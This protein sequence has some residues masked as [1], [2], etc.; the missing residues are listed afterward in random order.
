MP[1]LTTV[2]LLLLLGLTPACGEAL[3][4]PRLRPA[5]TPDD[6]PALLGGGPARSPRLAS[7]QIDARLDDARHVIEARQ[8]LTWTNGGSSPVSSMPLHLYL[9][10]FANDSTLLMT[11]LRGQM[12]R[13]EASAGGWGWIDVTSISE[14]LAGG[15]GPGPELRG[16]ARFA[17]DDHTVLELPLPRVV[18]P[19]ER[20]ELAMTFTAQLPEVFARTGHRGAFTMVGQWFPKPGVRVG[21]PGQETWS[22]L[23]FHGNA[24]FFADFGVYDVRLTVPQTHVIAATGVLTEST[25]HADGT[26]TLRYLAEDVHDFAWMADP[27]ME[28]ISALAQVGEHTVQV[29]VV[30]RPA[31]RE[32]ARRHLAAGVGAIEQFSARFGAYPWS[33]M[34]IVD[35]PLDAVDGAGGMEYPTL[36]TTA[37]DTALARPGM[38][39]PEF[40]TI[41]EIGHNWF[42]G[43]LASDEARE[44]WLDEGVNEWAD[45]VVMA[46]LYGEPTSALD[47]HGW[48]AESFR[49]RRALADD[50]ASLPAPIASAAAAF[51]DQD[52][53]ASA[54]Y[55]APMAALRT[56][57]L[58]V[59]RDVFAAR[60]KRY[61]QAWAFRHPTGEDLIAALATD[62]GPVDVRAVLTPALH[63]IGAVQL[64]IRAADCAPLHPPRGRFVDE[65]TGASR[66]VIAADAPATGAWRCQVVVA[67]L[68]PVPVP[69]D[70]ETRFTDGSVRRD[71]WHPAAGERWHRVTFDR[72]SPLA[73]VALDPDRTILLQDD[74]TEL[75]LRTRGAA[76]ASL[77]AGARVGFWSQAVMAG[78]G[79]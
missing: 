1:R 2:A 60:M 19:G 4:P 24:E 76:A 49:L 72:S 48:Q 9:N 39:L 12:R 47:W 53:Y 7:Y 64:R 51:A 31:Q 67:N 78:V 22:T 44:P 18:G 35:P 33:I 57:E 70:N 46:A 38:R 43:L 6:V 41:H 17:A 59:G 68:G 77:R 42:Q 75:R 55:A 40:V 45:G 79:L 27:F 74:P 20:I 37:G 21:P 54:S 5:P 8:V 73:E 14:V 71:R 23:P 3:G 65:A 32:F 56:V 15:A 29:R 66:L 28:T 11:S 61:A 13:A 63:E 36:V 50:P 10:A 34:T 69:V 30:H 25:D 58:L 26:R 16:L 52:T 62:G